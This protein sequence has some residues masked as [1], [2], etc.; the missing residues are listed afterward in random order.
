MGH[1]HHH[2]HSHGGDTS[3][4]LGLAFFLNLAFTVIELAGA[5]W[6]GSTA[7]A[8]DALHDLGDSIALA[9]AWA[10]Q[11]LADRPA[12]RRYSYGL[13]RL[14]LVAAFV[15]AMVLLVGGAVVLVESVPRLWDPGEPNASG[16]L[17]LALLGVV[18]NGMAVL[19]VRGGKSLNARVVSLHLLEDVLGW[20][21]VLVVSC[22]M[23][24][25]DVPVLD[26]LLAILITLWVTTS[27]ARN[28]RKTLVV[29]LQGTPHDVDPKALV[30]AAEA[31]E[32]VVA[33]RHVHVWSLEGEHN[34]LT[35]HLV[36]DA[37][38][39]SAGAEVREQVRAALSSL[40]VKHCTLELASVTNVPPS[41]EDCVPVSADTDDDAHD[42]WEAH[43]DRYKLAML[44]FGK[45]IPEAVRR[46]ASLVSGAE[47]VLEVACGT[48]LFTKGYAP[49]VGTV[50]ATDYADAMMDVARRRV[51]HM[52]N[53]RFDQRDINALGEP[54]DSFD[55]VVAANV[56]HLL[57]DLERALASLRG[58]L[59]P[60]G[61]LVVPTYCHDQTLRSKAVSAVLALGNFPGERRFTVKRLSTALETA[62]FEIVEADVIPGRL[63]LGFVVGRK[64]GPD[65]SSSAP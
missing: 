45:P 50:L 19:R 30:A 9:F 56:L 65:A 4:A 3:R 59:K 44:V 63:P 41:A 58:V 12:P 27:A 38:E 5:W 54:D 29:F 10:M 49:Q 57:P 43:A 34:V 17:A 42:Y 60:G 46:T 11:G 15:N 22:V 1:D 36:V 20:V 6:T 26:P 62:G 13:R 28:L 53:V 40:D 16:M 33:L 39:F 24:V 35:G 2:D 18:V 8:A 31:V 61:L 21:A 64:P 25:V 55:A 23:L 47:S 52:S 48:G 37:D 32:G 7:I 14:S 51:S